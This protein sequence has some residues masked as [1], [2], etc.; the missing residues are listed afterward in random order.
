VAALM[1]A[2]APGPVTRRRLRLAGAKTARQARGAFERARQAAADQAH[3][4]AD[5]L[6][7]RR[8]GYPASAGSHASRWDEEARQEVVSG[9]PGSA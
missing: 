3:R 1:L 6:E 8:A 9:E 5:A 4:L 7:E 2:P